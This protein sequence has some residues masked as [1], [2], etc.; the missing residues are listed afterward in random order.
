MLQVGEPYPAAV[1]DLY[2]EADE[3]LASARRAETVGLDFGPYSDQPGA[4]IVKD[5]QVRA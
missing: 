2:T 1:G 5:Y 3:T 4:V